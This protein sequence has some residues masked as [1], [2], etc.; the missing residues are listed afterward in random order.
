MIKI[1]EYEHMVRKKNVLVKRKEK[2]NVDKK[3]VKM[4]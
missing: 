4:T 3:K 1:K 2:K